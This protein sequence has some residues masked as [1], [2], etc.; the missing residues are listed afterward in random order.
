MKLNGFYKIA[1]L[2][3]DGYVLTDT[4][5]ENNEYLAN[6]L[7]MNGGT[8]LTK[9]FS[10]KMFFEG[11][12]VVLMMI[13]E[14]CKYTNRITAPAFTIKTLSSFTDVYME[15]LKKSLAELIKI[16]LNSSKFTYSSSSFS[17]Y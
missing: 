9:T 4:K 6:I 13:N 11:N 7:S 3:I 17:V 1:G 8:P 16:Q 12:N 15:M 2:T 10:F 5:Y 14:Q